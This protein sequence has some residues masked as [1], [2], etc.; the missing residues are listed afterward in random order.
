MNE[1]TQQ[2]ERST[3]GFARVARGLGDLGVHWARYGLEIG[4]TALENSATT[5]RATADLLGQ[6]SKRLGRGCE[7]RA[8]QDAPPEPPPPTA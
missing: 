8:A 3:D 7:T 2:T 6:V 5:L 4:R 1:N